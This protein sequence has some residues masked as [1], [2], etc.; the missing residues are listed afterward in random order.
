MWLTSYDAG[1]TNINLVGS[2]AASD[3]LSAT[4]I[5]MRP[6]T[7]FSTVSPSSTF[8]YLVDKV[9]ILAVPLANES[10]VVEKVCYIGSTPTIAGKFLVSVA[11]ALG[12]PKG[13]LFGQLKSGKPITLPNGRTIQPEEVL[14]AP[15]PGRHFAIIAAIESTN[16][17]LLN[18][19][20]DCPQ[21]AGLVLSDDFSAS[22]HPT[23]VLWCVVL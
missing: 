4:S 23:F 5:F 12:V 7:N 10:G 20:F 9:R 1:V 2:Q 6:F 15:E 18:A 17:S 14:E 3:F 19:L 22:P 8:E 16:S 11:N 13:P 21:F